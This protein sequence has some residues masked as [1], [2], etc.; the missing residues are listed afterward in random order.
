MSSDISFNTKLYQQFDVKSGIH[1]DDD[2]DQDYVEEASDEEEEE[3][4]EEEPISE[5]EDYVELEPA[6]FKE[7]KDAKVKSVY[8][9]MKAKER[10]SRRNSRANSQNSS[11][12]SNYSQNY[13]LNE[14]ALQDSGR[15]QLFG[16]KKSVNK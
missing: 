15:I 11:Y 7:Q 2:E 8:E 14:R 16:D 10:D 12:D 5:E 9:I 13:A 3:A 4:E 1:N 6:Q